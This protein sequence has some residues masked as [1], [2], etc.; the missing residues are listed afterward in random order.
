MY[1]TIKYTNYCYAKFVLCLRKII[2]HFNMNKKTNYHFQELLAKQNNRRFY[3]IKC[4]LETRKNRFF[5]NVFSWKMYCK[6]K[7]SWV[8]IW[9][10]WCESHYYI[11]I[12]FYYIS[13]RSLSN[14]MVTLGMFWI[15][16][17]VVKV[18]KAVVV[19]VEVLTSLAAIV[20]FCAVV[21]MADLPP[22]Q[23]S[24]DDTAMS[25]WYSTSNTPPPVVYPP[26]V[27]G[28]HGCGC[29]R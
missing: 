10:S 19:V 1:V 26:L 15:V 24:D 5:L 18:V 3:M 21:V 9:G 11:I 14:V 23:T 2:E 25:Y 20:R 12:S 7:W 27:D 17:E 4:L 16:V 6:K 22:L 28:N 29:G 8:V 13:D